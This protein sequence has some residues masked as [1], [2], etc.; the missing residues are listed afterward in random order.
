MITQWCKH[1][2]WRGSSF[3]TFYI[4]FSFLCTCK[5]VLFS[6][7]GARYCS[8]VLFTLIPAS[9]CSFSKHFTH[10]SLAIHLQMYLFFTNL[11]RQWFLSA[12]PCPFTFHYTEELDRAALYPRSYLPCHW[13][14]G[15]YSWRRSKGIIIDSREDRIVLYADDLM[16]VSN[17]Q[18]SLWNAIVQR[19]TFGDF[20]ALH[21]NSSKSFL[22]PLSQCIGVH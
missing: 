17:S 6:S 5:P 20:S 21:I 1:K 11:P 13:A 7:G 3:F 4:Y 22:M 19:N 8:A 12:T 16:F 2:D 14:P 9:G 10:L 15:N 18:L